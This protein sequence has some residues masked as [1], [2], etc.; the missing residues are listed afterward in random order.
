MLLCSCCC[1][2]R[3]QKKHHP[4]LPL[5]QAALT[6]TTNTNTAANAQPPTTTTTCKRRH[7]PSTSNKKD[8]NQAGHPHERTCKEDSSTV[9]GKCSSV[10]PWPRLPPPW[11]YQTHPRHLAASISPCSPDSVSITLEN[12]GKEEQGTC[13]FSNRR[14]VG[15]LALHVWRGSNPR[16]HPYLDT[17]TVVFLLVIVGR[18]SCLTNTESACASAPHS[19]APYHRICS[20]QQDPQV[21]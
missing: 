11:P 4:L 16:H 13:P 9:R 6:W 20:L 5:P 15:V 8:S 19:H 18:V 2:H 3:R 12:M 7:M 17:Q 21:W 10:S 1:S 14:A